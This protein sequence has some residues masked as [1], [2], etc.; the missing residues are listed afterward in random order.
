VSTAAAPAPLASAAPRSTATGLPINPP[1][2]TK[3]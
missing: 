1:P 3:P 2:S